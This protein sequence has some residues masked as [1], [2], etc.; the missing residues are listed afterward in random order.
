MSKKR[1]YM[2]VSNILNESFIT[3]FLWGLLGKVPSK[4]EIKKIENNIRKSVKKQNDGM[5]KIEKLILKKYGKKIKIKQ[6][7]ADEVISQSKEY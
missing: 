1:S 3:N 4:S 2:D 6:V 5:K 7:D